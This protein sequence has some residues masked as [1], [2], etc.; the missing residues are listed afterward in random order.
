MSVDSRGPGGLMWVASRAHLMRNVGP[1]PTNP[2]RLIIRDMNNQII[3]LI[4]HG[5][6]QYPTD[7]LGRRLVY[8]PTVELSDEGKIQ[9]VCLARSI[10]QREGHPLEILVTSPYP[11]AEQTAAILSREMGVKTI[12]TDD[13]LRDTHSTWSGILV[14]EFMA[15]FTE[16]RTFDDPRTLE[17]LEK[18]GKRMKATY[19][20]LMVG[21]E[22]KRMGIVSHGDPIRALWF[23][24]HHPQGSYP[25]YLELTKMIS[26]GAAQGIRLERNQSGGIEPNMEFIPGL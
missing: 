10:L 14:D 16:G 3:Y 12:V 15:I 11:R 22:A 24:L 23:R 19:D 20:D 6:P 1:L 25:P 13:R 17:T 9:C 26:L 4:R 18:L 2:V 5:S 21:F 8:G 7:H